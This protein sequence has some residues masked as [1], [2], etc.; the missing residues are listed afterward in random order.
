MADKAAEQDAC[1]VYKVD[2]DDKDLILQCAWDDA[3]PAVTLATMRKLVARDSDLLRLGEIRSAIISPHF[4]TWVGG[5]T[6][7]G[8]ALALLAIG[9][10][11]TQF[12]HWLTELGIEPDESE[13]T[14]AELGNKLAFA[15]GRS[16]ECAVILL[17]F[18][19]APM[20][21]DGELMLMAAESARMAMRSTLSI[22]S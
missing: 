2:F 19:L 14:A 13:R 15:A 7:F 12:G 10:R 16:P 21:G 5:A 6:V 8:V 18:T 9:F 3:L 20:Q 4:A 11:Q 17:F 22:C 1:V